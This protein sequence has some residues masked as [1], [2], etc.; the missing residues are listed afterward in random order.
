MWSELGDDVTVGTGDRHRRAPCEKGGGDVKG[1]S[2]IVGLG[3][4]EMGKVYGRSRTDFAAEAIA[5][6][7]EDA[8]LAASDV[9]GLLINANSSTDMVPML[10]MSLGLED[11]TLINAMN[12]AGSTAGAM[13]QYAAHA[14]DVGQASVVACVYADAPLREG[15]SASEGRYSGRMFAGEGFGSLPF[16][17]GAYGP[18]NVGYAFALR[19][20]MH[21]YRHDARPA[22]HDRG[23]PA[24]VGAEERARADEEADDARGLPRVALDRRAAAPVRLL[25]RLERRYRGDRHLGR[26]RARPEAAAGVPARLRPGCTRRQPACR[27]ASRGSTRARSARASWRCGWPASSSTTSTSS[28][29]TTATRTPSS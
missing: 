4:T 13:L 8:G 1:T 21:L 16:A 5:L 23:R 26:A 9:D 6:A 18:A 25:P 10:Q 14:I 29:S 7:L 15:G 11:L 20:H 27:D 3:L 28:S 17:Y 19:R 2:A 22:G 12:A 24:R